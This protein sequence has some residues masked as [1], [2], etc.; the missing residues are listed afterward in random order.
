VT[1]PSVAMS[2][3]VSLLAA[4]DPASIALVTF[5]API[6]AANDP[7]PVPVTSPVRAIV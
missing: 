7:V 6:V 2:V 4:I 1:V 3:P 5:N